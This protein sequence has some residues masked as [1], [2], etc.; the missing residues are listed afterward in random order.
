MHFVSN[1]LKSL[2]CT[3]LQIHSIQIPQ[4]PLSLYF[5]WIYPRSQNY[6]SRIHAIGLAWTLPHNLSVPRLVRNVFPKHWKLQKTTFRIVSEVSVFFFPYHWFHTVSRTHDTIRSR[7]VP[8]TRLFP[9]YCL[10]P[11]SRSFLSLKTP[12][13]H[14]QVPHKQT[15]ST[16]RSFW[17]FTHEPIAGS[18]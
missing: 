13:P 9:I 12:P 5:L 15:H 14:W 16:V 1:T 8:H 2:E 10:Q 4:L 7:T 17:H 3:Y 18:S 11:S 6:M